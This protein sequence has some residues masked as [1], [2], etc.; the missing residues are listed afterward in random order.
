MINI[1]KFTAPWCQPCKQYTPV[2]EAWIASRDDV[3]LAGYVDVDESPEEAKKY[4]ITGV[5]FTLFKDDYG[6]LLA[7]VKGALNKKQLNT[8]MEKIQA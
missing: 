8:V 6:I 1:T 5:P 4:G 7:G 3:V 2:L